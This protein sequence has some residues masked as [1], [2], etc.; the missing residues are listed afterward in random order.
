MS[1]A[2]FRI[3]AADG[4]RL[5]D[6]ASRVCQVMGSFDTGY[7]AGSRPV[8]WPAGKVPFWVQIPKA[9]THPKGTRLAA[10]E[11]SE[12]GI[13]WVFGGAVPEGGTGD[14]TVYYGYF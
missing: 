12:A 9:S 10:I 7:E 3:T 2:L 13:S 11:V 5:V 8:Q 6:G 4:V 1:N 14:S